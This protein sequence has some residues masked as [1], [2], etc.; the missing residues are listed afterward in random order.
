MD[1]QAEA[2]RNIAIDCQIEGNPSPSYVW[3]DLPSSN[4]SSPPGM[5]PYY[6]QQPPPG[7]NIPTAGLSVFGITR[8]IQKIYQNPG[9]HVMQ[10][11]A[12][13]RGK[14][15]KQEFFIN[16]LRQCSLACLFFALLAPLLSFV[17]CLERRGR[18]EWRS[19]K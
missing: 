19:R 9:R 3:Y 6:G 7:S 12:Q 10:C 11:Q 5:L 15:I 14:T 17:E 18:N 4:L 8:Q 2:L 13:S 16:V 1:L